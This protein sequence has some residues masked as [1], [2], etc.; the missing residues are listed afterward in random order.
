MHTRSGESDGRGNL[1]E[2]MVELS[3]KTAELESHDAPSL[4]WYPA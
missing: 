2:A 1:G 4:N 3:V